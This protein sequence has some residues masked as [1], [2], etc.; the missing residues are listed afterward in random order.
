MK[1][2]IFTYIYHNNKIQPF[3]QPFMEVNIQILMVWVP[4]I[5][6]GQHPVAHYLVKVGICIHDFCVCHFF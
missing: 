2:G 5:R 1:I 4:G 6:W 3:M